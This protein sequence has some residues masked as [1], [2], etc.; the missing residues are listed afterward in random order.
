MINH[1]SDQTPSIIYRLYLYPNLNTYEHTTFNKHICY[2]QPLWK[3]LRGYEAR[4]TALPSG[5]ILRDCARFQ[6]LASRILNSQYF[7]QLFRYVDTN[8]FDVS[9][10][11]FCTLKDLLTRHKVSYKQLTTRYFC[12]YFNP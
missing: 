1:D 3:L 9:T 6:S 2:L 7:Y 4:E 10:D 11:A 12:L 5:G 8:L